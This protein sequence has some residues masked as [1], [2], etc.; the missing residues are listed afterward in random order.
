M[1]RVPVLAPSNRYLVPQ[2]DR[3]WPHA[4]TAL[5]GVAAL[6]L[7]TLIAV[8]WPRLRSTSIHYQLLE[9]REEVRELERERHRLALELERL[10]APEV[11]AER[12]REL[13]LEAPSPGAR[14]VAP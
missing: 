11:L 1:V 6:L 7:S 9:L 3:R 4:L 5:L 8:G 12:A 14:E 10:R 13:G 2:R